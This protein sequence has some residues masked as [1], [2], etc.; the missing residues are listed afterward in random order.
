MAGLVEPGDLSWY[1]RAS[2]RRLCIYACFAGIACFLPI[3]RH[4]TW[5]TTR[6]HRFLPPFSGLAPCCCCRFQNDRDDF[7]NGESERSERSRG[8]SSL[9]LRT[10]ASVRLYFSYASCSFF[11]LRAGTHARKSH[12]REACF[13]IA[14]GQTMSRVTCSLSPSAGKCPRCFVTKFLYS[15]FL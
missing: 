9:D 1:P 15:H 13:V 3:T 11:E 8:I 2:G 5:R 4:S 7:L 12:S 14:D 10:T 6:A